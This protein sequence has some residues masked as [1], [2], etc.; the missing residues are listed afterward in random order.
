MN[1]R[2]DGRTALITGA[3]QGL[4]LEIAKTYI[5]A[6]ANIIICA[7]DK[8]LLAKNTEE[9]SRLTSSGQKVIHFPAD[10]SNIEE[11][12]NLVSFSFSHFKKIDILINNAGIQGPKGLVEE[13]DW[14]EWIKVIEINLYGSVYMC[15]KLVP[16]FR[17]NGYGKII[18]L[19]GG[20]ATKP[21]PRNSA[22][23][24]S[25]AAVVRFAESLAEELTGQKIDVNCIAPG[26]LNTRM[27]TEIIEAGPAKVGEAV[28]QKALEQE[29]QGGT[30]LIKAASLAVFLG[31][32]ASD[33][34]TG[35]LLSAVWD[36]WQSL[37]EHLSEVNKSDIFT[38]RRITPE[39]RGKN[40]PVK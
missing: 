1:Y 22:Y 40:W 14:K 7:R 38:L 32:S 4:G 29:R 5:K 19:S 30:A 10:V 24:T 11:I 23:A 21:M 3:S 12:E 27:L 2:L 9:L 17:A 31:S 13:A 8:E 37:P 35:R 33:G 16:H 26:A 34:I 36:D 18:Q 25:K 20:G 28:Y 39:D 15:R 6:G